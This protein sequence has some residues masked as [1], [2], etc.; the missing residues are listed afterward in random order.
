MATFRRLNIGLVLQ[1]LGSL[2]L[3]AQAVSLRNPVLTGVRGVVSCVCV[4]VC[5]CVLV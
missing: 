2:V 5:V 4:C 3:T 1:S